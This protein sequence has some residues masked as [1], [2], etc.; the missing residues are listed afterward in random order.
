MP[1]ADLKLTYEDYRALPETGPWYQ[2]VGGELVMTPAPRLRHQTVAVR[3]FSPLHAFVESRSL[4][5]VYFAPVDVIL[6]DADAVQSDILYVSA[7][8][9]GILVPEGVRGSPDLCVEV[10]S[11][12]SM[13]LDR[14][15]KR[16]LFAEHGVCD[17]WLVD[18]EANSIEVFRLQ[19]VRATPAAVFREDEILTTD[20]LPGL[21]LGVNDLFAP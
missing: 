10:L 1:R 8:R 17:V 14:G 19:E 7:A 20:L 9:R 4:G 21:A 13:A 11:E 6:S 15:A 12:S 16:E 5:S 2:L 3:L 18:P